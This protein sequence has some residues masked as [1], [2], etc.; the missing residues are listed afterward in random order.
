VAPYF[1]RISSKESG[2]ATD[3]EVMRNAFFIRM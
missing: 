2:A 3:P 1:T